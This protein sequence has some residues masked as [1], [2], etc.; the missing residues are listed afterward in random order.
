MTTGLYSLSSL[1]KLS[2]STTRELYLF[3]EAE[4]GNAPTLKPER[5]GGVSALESSKAAIR[6]LSEDPGC[7]CQR[8]WVSLAEGWAT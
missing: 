3:P 6:K 5:I 7:F 1:I 4:K 2:G 8:S